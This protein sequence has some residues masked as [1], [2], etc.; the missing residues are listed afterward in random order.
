M[1]TAVFTAAFLLALPFCL[2]RAWRSVWIPR[3]KA[4]GARLRGVTFHNVDFRRATLFGADITQARFVKPAGLTQRVLDRAV[5]ASWG[6]PRL[7][8]SRDARTGKPL[9]WRGAC[10]GTPQWQLALW[11]CRMFRERFQ[12]AAAAAHRPFMAEPH[13]LAQPW[14]P[15]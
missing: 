9:V 1:S 10:P 8:G 2:L 3:F 14:P 15:G 11:P 5:A 6:P 13:P 12:R 7:Y 4:A